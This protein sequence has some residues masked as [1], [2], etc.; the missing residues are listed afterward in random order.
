GGDESRGRRKGSRLVVCG[1][2]VKG[3]KCGGGRQG[4]FGRFLRYDQ[5]ALR[6]PA[7][8]ASRNER[9]LGQAFAVRRI[10]KHQRE[11]L[12][13]MCGPEPRRIAP[14]DAADT[15]KPERSNIL[16]QQGTRLGGIVD[17]QRQG[18]GARGR[19]EAKRPGAGE[20]IEHA[21]ADDRVAIGVNEN[22]EQ[23]LAQLIRGR[24]DCM[25]ARRRERTPAESATDD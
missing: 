24:A 10:E 15:A 25:R 11:W 9:L 14:E 8:I 23:G 2:E 12:E 13:R 21:C 7:A 19:V 5:R 4:S 16:A 6:K 3:R 1:A 17:Q 18:R 20:K 22:V